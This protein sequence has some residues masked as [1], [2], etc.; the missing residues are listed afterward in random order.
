M[1]IAQEACIP[2]SASQRCWGRIAFCSSLILTWLPC[3]QS[4]QSSSVLTTLL[5]AWLVSTHGGPILSPEWWSA[6]ISSPQSIIVS[7]TLWLDPFSRSFH[8]NCLLYRSGRLEFVSLS[9]LCLPAIRTPIVLKAIW[10]SLR[11][12]SRIEITQMKKAQ[13][14]INVHKGKEISWRTIHQNIN[15]SYCWVLIVILYIFSNLFL[16]QTMNQKK[17]ILVVRII[18]LLI[19]TRR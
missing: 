4:L 13:D 15:N 12:G 8:L 3:T 19:V 18:V 1:M 7:H 6:Q 16:L 11:E 17:M 10:F 9:Y 14:I 5:H 2:G